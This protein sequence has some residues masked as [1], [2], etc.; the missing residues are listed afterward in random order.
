MTLPPSQGTGSL[1]KEPLDL[2]GSITAVGEI[3][4]PETPAGP[5][6]WTYWCK[7]EIVGGEIRLALGAPRRVGANASTEDVSA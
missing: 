2:D 6:P 5:G 7:A 4:I 1:R 3:T